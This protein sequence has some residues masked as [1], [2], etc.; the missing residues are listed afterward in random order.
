MGDSVSTSFAPQIMGY[1]VQI[2]APSGILS[3]LGCGFR[4]VGGWKGEKL[5]T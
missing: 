2:G 5:K 1:R 4:L 3:H